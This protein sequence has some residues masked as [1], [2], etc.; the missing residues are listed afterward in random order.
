MYC[1]HQEKIWANAQ[2]ITFLKAIRGQT[3]EK[4]ECH[5]HCSASMCLIRFCH[6]TRWSGQH[7]EVFKNLKQFNSYPY[8]YAA[9]TNVIFNTISSRSR[10]SYMTGAA[11]PEKGAEAI[12]DQSSKNSEMGIQKQLPRKMGPDGLQ[13][14]P[15][16]WIC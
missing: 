10:I 16:T 15:P 5:E 9:Y 14:P 4:P 1:S 8:H 13:R 3:H 7:Q 12:F 2:D 11:D 6:E